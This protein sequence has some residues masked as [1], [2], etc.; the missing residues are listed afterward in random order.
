MH[1][2]V[3]TWMEKVEELVKLW[4]ENQINKTWIKTPNVTLIVKH[5]APVEVFDICKYQNV[6]LKMTQLE[7]QY[8]DKESLREGIAISKTLEPDK[9]AASCEISLVGDA[10]KG[11]ASN[12]KHCLRD[13]YIDYSQERAILSFRSSDFLKKFLTD[14]YFVQKK[15][16]AANGR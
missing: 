4:P 15:G 7:N 3:K 13:V 1:P 2:V 5:V 12:R 14:I 8:I 16:Y 9:Y 11:S 10:K 6:N